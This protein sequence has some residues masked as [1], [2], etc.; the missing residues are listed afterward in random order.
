MID[1][2]I[3]KTYC[4]DNLELMKQ[5]DDNSIDL[6]YS[7]I[8]YGTGKKFKD[9]QDLKPDRKVIEEFYIPRIKE[10]QRILKDTGSIYLQMDYRIVHW[11]RQI[12]DDVFGYENFQNEI[13]WNYSTGGATS[14]RYANK[15]DNILFYS[16]SSNYKFYAERI[17]EK[18]TEKS[19]KR[20]KNPNGARITQDNEYKLPTDV[21][22]ISALNPMSKE[23]IGYDTQKPLE[24]MEKIIKASSNE[25][26]IIADFFMGSGSF[27]V[28]AKELNRK[29]VGCDINT[30][31]VELTNER[32]K[33]I[34]NLKTNNK[35]KE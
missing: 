34:H 30:R 2:F 4:M 35:N 21:W 14:E 9:Y 5:I 19:L 28:K 8:L 33:Q 25:G 23:R 26:N 29:Y 27:L 1:N 32:L 22:Q 31:A 15:H 18:R 3:N 17:K 11:I 6:I 24:L 20:A 16:K 7:D 12:M 13:I 10:M